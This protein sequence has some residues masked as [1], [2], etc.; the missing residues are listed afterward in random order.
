MIFLLKDG[1]IV[2]IMEK[3]FNPKDVSLIVGLGNP[4]NKYIKTYHNIGA[5]YV[6]HAAAL[7][8]K[9][10]QQNFI[11]PSTFMNESGQAVKATLKRLNKK[12]ADI[13]VVHDDSD[14]TLGK[15]KLSFGRGAAGHNGVLSI[16]TSLHTKNF[17]RLRVGI[18]PPSSKERFRE[19]ASEFVLKKIN[20]AAMRVLENA[21]LEIDSI[22]FP[23]D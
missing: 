5:L 19:K 23:K 3:K 11:Q 10:E 18:R 21:F 2:R 16:M 4:G 14:L 13:L 15:Y 6:A 17:W 7:Q 9:T 12:P 1:I 20:S 8:T 22:I